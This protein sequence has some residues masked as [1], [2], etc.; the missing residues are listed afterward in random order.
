[1]SYVIGLD[2]G[3][4]SVRALLVNA[5]SGETVESSVFTYPRWGQRLYCDAS[6]SQ[7]RQHPLDHL[8]GL[9]KT[10]SDVVIKS[11]VD[12]KQIKGIC[13]DTTGSSPMAVNERGISLAMVPGY[14][15]NP[16]AMMVLW[17]D[18][19]AVKNRCP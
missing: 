5:V 12:K 16:N 6:K 13:V 3:T 4:D 17:K 11:G 9:E 10:V 15:E 2:Y 8:E 1:M 19:T 14:E 7:F 18:H